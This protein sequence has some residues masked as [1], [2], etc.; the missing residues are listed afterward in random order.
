MSSKNCCRTRTGKRWNVK[1]H[2]ARS[3]CIQV[4]WKEKIC[5]SSR[6]HATGQELRDDHS[7]I[8]HALLIDLEPLVN[9]VQTEQLLVTITNPSAEERFYRHVIAFA[10]VDQFPLIAESEAV[11]LKIRVIRSEYLS[12]EIRIVRVRRRQVFVAIIKWFGEFSLELSLNYKT[13]T[14]SRYYV[15]T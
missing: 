12:E 9:T 4:D 2:S 14:C 10:F 15:I 3:C 13:C 1:W 8:P 6:S 5:F 11:G 7:P